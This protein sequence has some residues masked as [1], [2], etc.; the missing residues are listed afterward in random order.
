M[1]TEVIPVLVLLWPGSV[2]TT[3]KK[4]G[5]GYPQLSA[6]LE[7][8]DA[9]HGLGGHIISVSGWVGMV[10]DWLLEGGGNGYQ[11]EMSGQIR[12]TNTHIHIQGLRRMCTIHGY[13]CTLHC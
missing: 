9:A 6:V 8:A 11:V 3:R 10:G 7:C 13:D 1:A 4:A 5:V 2:C 12:G